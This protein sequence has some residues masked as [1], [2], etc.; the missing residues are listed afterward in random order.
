MD[1]TDFNAKRYF[2]CSFSKNGPCAF[3]H[4]AGVGQR[5]SQARARANAVEWFL[6]FFFRLKWSPNNNINQPGTG[7]LLNSRTKTR[8]GSQLSHFFISVSHLPARPLTVALFHLCLRSRPPPSCVCGSF[9]MDTESRPRCV[10]F[11]A[12]A[13]AAA[14]PLP[15]DDDGKPG[16]TK[17]TG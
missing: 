5:R 12:A 8:R 14:A 9:F 15:W 1:Q 11:A 6:K 7:S 16:L 13:A 17:K 10:P 4:D 3:L 2:P